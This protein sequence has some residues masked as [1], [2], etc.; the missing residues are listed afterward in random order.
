MKFIKSKINVHAV[1][2]MAALLFTPFAIY[3]HEVDINYVEFE[4]SVMTLTGNTFIVLLI[5][6]IIAAGLTLY[7]AYTLK[8]KLTLIMGCTFVCLIL[9]GSLLSQTL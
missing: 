7:G 6:E 2:L 9:T 4:G 8:D 3:T 1:L 5:F